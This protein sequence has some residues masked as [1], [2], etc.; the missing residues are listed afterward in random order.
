MFNY[1]TS[2]YQ[3][4]AQFKCK[5]FTLYYI[6][7]S[8]QTLLSLSYKGFYDGLIMCVRQKFKVIVCMCVCVC[9]MAADRRYYDFQSFYG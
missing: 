8:I 1:F 2:K 3:K 4:G 5:W 9:V 7:D 6:V